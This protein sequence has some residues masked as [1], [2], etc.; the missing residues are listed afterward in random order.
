MPSSRKNDC[1]L[2]SEFPETEVDEAAHELR[3][4]EA[5]KAYKEGVI[6]QKG[7]EA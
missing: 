4:R 1:H 7:F 3:E 2:V 6:L 5:Q